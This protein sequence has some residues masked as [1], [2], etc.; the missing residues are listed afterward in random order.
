[1]APPREASKWGWVQPPNAK[2][3]LGSSL[4]PPGACMTPSR[5]VKVATVIRRMV[6]SRLRVGSMA[7]G[8]RR[9]ARADRPRQ[10]FYAKVSAADQTHGDADRRADEQQQA[11]RRLDE[12]PGQPLFH[13]LA[14]APEIRDAADDPHAAE[15]RGAG[16]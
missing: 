13:V 3:P 11:R 7:Q 12:E 16:I 10:I 4:G 14:V 2:P 15:H 1:M 8:R 5:L 6:A 9:G